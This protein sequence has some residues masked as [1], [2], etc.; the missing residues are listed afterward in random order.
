[1][2]Y[3]FSCFE[4]LTLCEQW[5]RRGVLPDKGGFLTGVKVQS[6]RVGWH[7]TGDMLRA[8]GTQPGGLQRI[9]PSH[10][11]LP[12]P[13]LD[14]CR[15]SKGSRTE[16]PTCTLPLRYCPTPF[17]KRLFPWEL[18]FLD[19]TGGCPGSGWWED[20]RFGSTSTSDW[21]GLPTPKRWTRVS[22]RGFSEAQPSQPCCGWFNFV[23]WSAHES[24]SA[25]MSTV[26]S[27]WLR[28]FL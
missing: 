13:L 27:Q 23:A 7:F 18:Y 8:L 17:A 3:G 1:M 2:G 26:R 22:Q 14:V 20:T 11:G 25:G 16:L 6:S 21:Q 24:F 10:S 28:C 5:Y 19:T 15:Y 12:K 9:V 4:P